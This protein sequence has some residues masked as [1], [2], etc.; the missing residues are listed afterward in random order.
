MAQ[1]TKNR[2]LFLTFEGGEGA[3][4]TTQIRRLG[5][6]LSQREIP[7]LI[8]H[9]PGATDLGKTVREIVLG[10][11]TQGLS[12]RAELLLYEADRAQHVETFLL[13]G[14]REGRVVLCDR[15]ADSSTVYQ[16]ICRGLGERETA[17][18]NR[19]ATGGLRPDRVFVFDIPEEEG[20]ARARKRSGTLDRLES[21]ALSFHRKV[22]QGFLKLARQNRTRFTV[23]DARKSPDEIAAKV[24]KVLEPMLKRKGL[25]KS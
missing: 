19:F 7:N 6:W 1:V 9:E 20:L 11:R 18:L 24:L 15:F 8:T 14:L 4:K 21:E 13:P 3:G 2:G 5:E 12:S 23:I 10:T 22:R 17:A 16:G 25:W